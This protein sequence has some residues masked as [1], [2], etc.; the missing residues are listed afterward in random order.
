MKIKP[1]IFGIVEDNSPAQKRKK[2]NKKH[3]NLLEVGRG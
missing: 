2:K 3:L 1:E